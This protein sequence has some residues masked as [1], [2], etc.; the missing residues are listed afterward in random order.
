VSI[1]PA[2]PH[3]TGRPH[4]P[5]RPRRGRA[6][7]GAA[8]AVGI[9]GALALGG[10]GIIP[11]LGGDPSTTGSAEA[12]NGATWHVYAEGNRVESVEPEV[13][14]P[15]KTT[16]GPLE[17]PSSDANLPDSSP[18]P[19]CVDWL[20]QGQINGLT[21]EVG[22]TPGTVTV[23][24]PNTVDPRLISYRL[25]TTPQ[26]LPGGSHEPYDWRDV[27]P[28]PDCIEMVVTIDKLVSGRRYVFWLDAVVTTAFRGVREPMIARSEAITAP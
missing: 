27:Q 5:R 22:T 13:I 26:Q 20:E 17:L 4:A 12:G 8:L 9:A 21:V 14:W 19:I 23:R 2:V 25:A 6:L 24:W 18:G 11:G 10:C 15:A 1:R 3:R 28:A 7:L 16:R